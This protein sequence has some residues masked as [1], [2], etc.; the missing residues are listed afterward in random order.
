MLASRR[1]EH[2]AAAVVVVMTIA[3]LLGIVGLALNVGYRL[4]VRSELQTAADAAA[5]AGA[6]EL[7]GTLAPITA[8]LPETRAISFAG[9]HTS[10]ASVQVAISGSDVQLGRWDPWATNPATAFTPITATDAESAWNTNAVRVRDGRER[11]RGSAVAV[12]FAAFLGGRPTQDVTA[13]AVA[14]NGGPCQQECPNVPFAFSDCL[15]PAN[16]QDGC[17]G[18]FHSTVLP[19]GTTNPDPTDTMGFTSLSDQLSASV[20]VFRDI[21]SG[22]NCEDFSVRTDQGINVSNGSN[23]VP[24]CDGLC[25]WLDRE[26]VVPVIH[27][28]CPPRF[29][30]APS[31][32]G[33][34]TVTLID[35]CGCAS[36]A[37]TPRTPCGP[38]VKRVTFR[39]ECNRTVQSADRVGC[40]FFGTGMLQPKLV[41]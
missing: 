15:M 38:G 2:G 34:A 37:G 39:L 28:S 12:W 36:C 17:G 35:I 24:L 19:P 16:F 5:L 32:M 27:E 40:G 8:A 11:T 14:V 29:N 10:G 22:G 30:Q 21:L 18:T 9:R 13:E 41:R 31:V 33:F 6:R 23:L 4:D 26:T 20:P 25:S 3:A 7:N 1:P